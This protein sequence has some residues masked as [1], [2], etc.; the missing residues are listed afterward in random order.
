MFCL[1]HSCPSVNPW[2]TKYQVVGRTVGTLLVLL[3]TWL[4]GNKKI[5]FR[6]GHQVS[7]V[8]ADRALAGGQGSQCNDKVCSATSP[9]PARPTSE[10]LLLSDD[11]L[12]I[13]SSQGAHEA[14]EALLLQTERR[15]K[16]QVGNQSPAEQSLWL[17]MTFFFFFIPRV[18]GVPI[19]KRSHIM[20]NSH[21]SLTCRWT[22]Q[23]WE[24]SILY[25][26]LLMRGLILKKMFDTVGSRK[27]SR[28]FIPHLYQLF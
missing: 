24:K 13:T 28:W 27:N 16:T 21:L 14:R 8:S 1:C 25:K 15:R 23:K 7:H 11:L 5:A 18:T 20:Q 9:L 12:L 4:P 26:T 17:K 3:Q 22:L 6:W 19:F 10:L 2:K